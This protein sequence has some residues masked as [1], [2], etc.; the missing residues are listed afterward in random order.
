R[1]AARAFSG[2]LIQEPPRN[3]RCML[4]GLPRRLPG[5]VHDNKKSHE[6]RCATLSVGG[7]S[8]IS[9]SV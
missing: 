8:V 2:L 6:R 5:R 3:T 4:I 7:D 9:D 1:L